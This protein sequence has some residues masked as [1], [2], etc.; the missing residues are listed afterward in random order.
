MM[1]EETIYPTLNL[2]SVAEDCRGIRHVMKPLS[3]DIKVMI[4]NCFAFG[5]INAA[6]VCRRLES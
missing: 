3:C 5:G 1:E 4:K 2:E 6:L